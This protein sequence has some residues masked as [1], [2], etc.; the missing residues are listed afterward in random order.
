MA[1]SNSVSIRYTYYFLDTVQKINLTETIILRTIQDD[2]GQM[3][4]LEQTFFYYF[5]K[6]WGVTPLHPPRN[7]RPRSWYTFLVCMGMS[8][9][10][11]DFGPEK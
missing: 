10:L 11:R 8:I 4:H 2:R 9:P 7:V 3:V 6:L 1:I 5:S